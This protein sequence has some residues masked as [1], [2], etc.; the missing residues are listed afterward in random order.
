MLFLVANPAVRSNLPA[1]RQGFRFVGHNF[2]AVYELPLVAV[3]S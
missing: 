2:K 3:Y 1:G